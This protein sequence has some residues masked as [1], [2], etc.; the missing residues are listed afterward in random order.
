MIRTDNR[1]IILKF[2]PI[3]FLLVA[4]AIYF[5]NSI[6]N[7]VGA[8]RDDTFI[9]LW[10]GIS[11]AEGH[12]LVNYNFEPVEMSSS[13]LH[14]LVIGVIHLFAPDFIYS[15]N[16]VL[17]LLAGATLLIVLHQK[18]YSLFGN[19]VSG[20][21]ALGITYF[22]LA[23]SRSWLY[24]N[25][26]GL[27][28]PFQTLILF[29]YGLSLIEF[30]N[31]PVRVFPLVV[32]Q[33][34]YLFVRPEGFTLIL[35]TAVFILG[36]AMF[37]RAFHRKQIALLLGIPSF[38]LFI[39]LI[40]R[41]LHFGLLFPNPV[42]AKVNFAIDGNTISTLR[43][44]I[45]YLTGFYTSSPYITGQLAILIVLLI[46]AVYSLVRGKTR[47]NVERS[48]PEF[49][50]VLWLGLILLNHLFV[51]ITGGDWMEFFRFLAPVVPLMVVLTTGFA[52]KM[53]NEVI[54]KNNL[55][56][57]YL[58]A[59]SN[60]ALGAVFLILIATNSG[61]RDNYEAQD[62]H[63]CSERFDAAKVRAI[64]LDYRHL[65]ENLILMNCAGQ[66][67]WNGLMLFMTGELPKAYQLLD[68][69]ITIATFQMGFLPY[70]IKKLHPTMKIRF[71]DTLGI[72]D[73]NVARLEGARQSYGL[74]EGTRIAE[75]LAGESGELSNY[76]L[77]QN[78]N[79]IYVLNATI[80]RR[81]Q[82]ADLG[83]AVEL[84]KPGAVIFIKNIQH[85]DELFK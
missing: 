31:T 11:L 43:T 56:R 14:T 84:D 40:T 20:T 19:D 51:I 50:F 37:H 4:L 38:F 26:G 73:T 45:K 77:S 3:S 29:L 10:T 76:V 13:L 79:M 7:Y 33:T 32:L 8:G 82:L 67:D 46:W 85:N 52:Y 17:G 57:P 24:W 34:L 59:S 15:I 62:F 36:R 53:I 49:I 12:G 21:I 39:I 58:E 16:K 9:T 48:K 69:N 72:G 80:R 41:Y 6:A 22:G 60:I 71:I 75:I 5:Y 61:Q 68:Q 25:L 1:K 81:Q 65:D 54:K 23:N 2:I 55:S 64:S 27:E 83:W 63:N 18:R 74:S 30:W 70:Y 44:G 42:Y 47:S 66:R 28:T 35:F 78:P